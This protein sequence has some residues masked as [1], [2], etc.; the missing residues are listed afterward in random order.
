MVEK[1]T[2]LSS[3]DLDDGLEKDVDGVS[4]R[5]ISEHVGRGLGENHGQLAA[6]EKL[7]IG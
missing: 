6:G 4:V 7:L 5:V 1:V 2:G 3:L